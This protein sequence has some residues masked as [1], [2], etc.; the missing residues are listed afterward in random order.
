MQHLLSYVRRCVQDYDML[1]EGDHVAVGVSGGKDSLTTLLVL[2]ALSGF[3]PQHFDVR[4]ISIDMGFP[5]ADFSPIA[6]LCERIEVP[7]TVVPTQIY[8][9][10]FNVRQEKNPCSLCANMR[11]GALNRAAIAHGCNKVAL[12]HHRDDAVETFLLSEFYEGRIACFQPV[13]FL[14]RSGVTLI[15][16]MLYVPE[17]EMRAFARRQELPVFPR[18]CPQ[19]GNSRR[20]EVKALI[21]SLREKNPDLS[22]LLFG[23]IQRSSLP[24]WREPSPR[25]FI[26][27][28]EHR[29]ET[30]D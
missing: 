19:E 22:E 29:D 28:E 3:Y 24:G 16:P 12:G 20:A 14:D 10:V 18:L 15:R 30:S 8:E 17:K 21:A 4:A 9:L 7:F 2:K 25:K 6:A 1:A 5:G 27:P 11:R 13:T 26:K 23:A